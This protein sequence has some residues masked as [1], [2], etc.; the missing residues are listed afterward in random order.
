MVSIPILET[1][2]HTFC[3]LLHGRIIKLLCQEFVTPT[4]QMRY[5][6]LLRIMILC[7]LPAF[8]YCSTK[9]G[10]YQS[11][12]ARDCWDSLLYISVCPR[13]IV[14]HL[15]RFITS[16]FQLFSD[17]AFDFISI[18]LK[19]LQLTRFLELWP[20]CLGQVL[21]VLSP[22]HYSISPLTNLIRGIMI[23]V[24]ETVCILIDA[25]KVKKSLDLYD[26]T[27]I[28]RNLKW[29]TVFVNGPKKK[30]SDQSKRTGQN[31]E[32]Q[33]PKPD[34]FLFKSKD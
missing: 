15:V 30:S 1:E 7:W 17:P 24:N 11:N 3:P 20:A 28:N 33:N 9:K 22:F 6:T 14:S 27:Y 13:N 18:P 32:G 2:S 26:N 25:L 31:C 12:F 21:N 4:C 5:Q 19:L 16:N 29:P 23:T 34:C 8:K 10:I